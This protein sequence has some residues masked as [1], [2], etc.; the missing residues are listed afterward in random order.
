[1]M[2]KQ[3]NGVNTSGMYHAQRLK[4]V[5]KCMPN[6]DGRLSNVRFQGFPD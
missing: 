3:S 5:L 6:Y 1:M 2:W 4:I